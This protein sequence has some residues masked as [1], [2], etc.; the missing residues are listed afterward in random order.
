[1]HALANTFMPKQQAI[2]A[3]LRIYTSHRARYAQRQLCRAKKSLKS[4]RHQ[5]AIFRPAQA[6]SSERAGDSFFNSPQD[7]VFCFPDSSHVQ[8]PVFS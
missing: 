8:G 2:T 7:T 3:A 4:V 1:M 6:V 5:N